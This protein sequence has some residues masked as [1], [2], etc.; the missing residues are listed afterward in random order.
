MHGAVAICKALATLQER[1]SPAD[2]EYSLNNMQYV[3]HL[4]TMMVNECLVGQ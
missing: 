3:C 4:Q 2:V 1:Q